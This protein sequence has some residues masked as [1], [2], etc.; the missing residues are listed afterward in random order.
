MAGTKE[1]GRK[2]AAKNLD[3]N[4]NFYNEI[5]KKG[6][7]KG[8]TGGFY[9]HPELAKI[10]GR[11][12]GAISRRNLDKSSIASLDSRR[13]KYADQVAKQA[14]HDDFIMEKLLNIV[15]SEKENEQD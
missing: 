7:Q 9:A 10:A 13:K 1:G 2:A 15:N 8:H 4:P 12:G 14:E 3:K 6:G 11:K 5:G